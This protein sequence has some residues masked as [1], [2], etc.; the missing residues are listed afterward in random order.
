MQDGGDLFISKTNELFQ[1]ANKHLFLFFV[2]VSN[3]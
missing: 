1:C 3:P 2:K